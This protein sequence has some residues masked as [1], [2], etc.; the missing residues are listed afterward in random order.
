MTRPV[1]VAI[2]ELR[3]SDRRK[4]VAVDEAIRH[5]PDSG[6]P[7]RIDVPGGPPDRQYFAIAPRRP[8]APVVVYRE[9]E[10]DEGSDGEWLVTTLIERDKYREYLRAEQ[11]GLLDTPMV[12][13]VTTSVAGTV[14]AALTAVSQPGTVR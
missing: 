6:E 8:D 12:R 7:L 3:E 13:E 10:P 1:A 4:A 14:S 11:H 2:R 5:I 9:L